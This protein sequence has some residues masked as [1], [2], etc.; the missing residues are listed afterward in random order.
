MRS[1]RR[2]RTSP[3]LTKDVARRIRAYTRPGFHPDDIDASAL[4]ARWRDEL[5]GVDGSLN[6]RLGSA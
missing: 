6:E 2:L 5:F 1:L 3:F 4:V